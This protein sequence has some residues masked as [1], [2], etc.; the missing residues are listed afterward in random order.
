MGLNVVSVG[1]RH[2]KVWRLEQSSSPAKGRRGL[3]SISDGSSAS[4]I[5]RTFTG[6]NC[7]LGP[8]QDAVFTCV[9]GI[10]NDKSVLCTQDGAVCLLD[11]VSRSQR[12][13]QVAKKDYSITC[14]T[15]DQSAGVVW[16]G[17]K[18]VEPEA[19]PLDVLLQSQELP[20]VLGKSG[21][22]DEVEKPD[23]TAVC[24]IDNRVITIDTSHCIAIYSSIF[25]GDDG[26]RLSA[27]KNFPSH[28]STILGVVI[29]PKPN[30]RRSD[31]LT[32][33]ENGRVLY[34]R[35][36]GTCTR[37]H[38]VQMIQPLG[39]DPTSSN[40]LQTL[41]VV[42]PHETLLTGDRAGIL[43]LSDIDEGMETCVKAHDGEIYD[44][45]LQKVEGGDPV[46]ASCG[47]DRTIQVFRI[48][49]NECLLQQSM[50]NEHAGPIRKVR[51][52][53]NANILVSMSSDRTIVLHHKV[54]RT[55]DSI[56]FVSI[57]V[58]TLKASPVTMSLVP[59][60]SPTLLVST[61]D[62]CIRTISLTQGKVID[63]FKTADRSG[64]EPV[65]L[66]RLSVGA[67]HQL[68]AH[69]NVVAGFSSVDGSIRLYNTESGLLLAAVQGQTVISD[70][71]I[72]EA[73]DHDDGICSK[74]VSAGVDGT[75]T[76]WRLTSSLSH[77]GLQHESGGIDPS[78]SQARSVLRPLRRLL[79]K[80]EIAD[81]QRTLKDGGDAGISSRS[82]SPSR[83]RKKPLRNAILD[84]SK[85][86]ETKSQ[87]TG[88]ISN[89]SDN[90]Q[91]KPM[92]ASSP[93]SPRAEMHHGSGLSSLDDLSGKVAVGSDVSSINSVA[94][95]STSILQDFRSRIAT[96]KETLDYDI[97]QG[98]KEELHATLAVL[99][100]Q[101][102]SSDPK[103]KGTATD[104]ESFDSYLARLIDDR[105][106]LR[107]RTDDKKEHN[108][109]QAADATLTSSTHS[110][111]EGSSIEQSLAE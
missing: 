43:R 12:L 61:A 4:P 49:R 104:C 97:A 109:G 108:E 99:A 3:D 78:K 25:V 31:F 105:L 89:S 16:I 6:R 101:S 98:V 26:P 21:V 73:P 79:S 29:L 20:R 36:N 40:C 93:S 70:L 51:L 103:G 77:R 110:A 87:A 62:R 44:L 8:L 92:R 50:V 22:V 74:V 57:K 27:M 33:S 41:G 10:S 82:L 66:S 72:A 9:V 30:K 102:L 95:R 32:Y 60:I 75:T 17:G 100:Q 88:T 94:K 111:A 56:A 68:S 2:V 69:G 64:G 91:V 1:T 53:E 71:A 76:V 55:D 81:F 80:T 39:Q 13:L 14:V 18:G 107:L 5:P 59:G 83:V 47:K 15:L 84:V 7:L 23:T 42:Q 34:W 63:S 86:T 24:C 96:S 28:D 35:W 54:L 106:A 90:H 52:T 46:A 67:S 45:A 11:D 58:I 37:N 65:V 85:V 38:L 48:S 19:L